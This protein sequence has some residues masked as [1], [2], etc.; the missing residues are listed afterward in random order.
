MAV[1]TEQV[2][3]QFL[4]V[5]TSD[6]LQNDYPAF[7]AADVY[8]FY[9]LAGNAA[10]RN[11][12]Y[13]VQLGNELNDYAFTVTVL[14]SLKAKID[15]MI[16]ADPDE[17]NK[18]VVR[19][20]MQYTTVTQPGAVS[21]TKFTSQEFDRTAMKLMQVAEASERS[22]KLGPQYVDEEPPTLR[23]G[24]EGDG[25]MFGPDNTIIP[26]PR[27]SDIGNVPA[28]AAQ[29]VVDAAQ[30][31]AD[32]VAVH[33]DKLAADA[34]AAS[35]LDSK[36][37]AL[38]T[39]GIPRG[40]WTTA[41]AYGF[42]DIARNGTSQYVC[43]VAHTSGVFATD[44]SAG[45]WAVW[46]S[47]GAP[48]AGSGDMSKSTYDPTA[49]NADAFNMAN[50]VESAA[51]SGH[52]KLSTAE[53]TKLSGIEAGAQVVSASRLAT[54][55]SG[56]SAGVPTGS[57][58]VVILSAGG[59]WTKALFSAVATYMASALG[60]TFAALSHSHSFA[61]IVSKPSTRAGYGITDAAPLSPNAGAVGSYAFCFTTT[62]G[63]NDFGD[64]RSG[65]QLRPCNSDDVPATGSTLSGTW[66]CMGN[67]KAGAGDQ[68]V[69]LWLRVS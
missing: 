38:Q 32:R 59:A 40:D 56:V 6:V 26:G 17:E 35:A 13:T 21:N 11:T 20:I 54:T 25:L 19:R 22:V 58:Y 4:N 44:V 51:G 1:T 23:L 46:V 8:V 61:D 53:R 57:D 55:T 49:K 67:T 68:V 60:T 16:A 64:T 29:V 37:V 52:L 24:V 41:T 65:S 30:V 9:G 36:N 10:V 12:D 45:K 34:D 63:N 5:D 66:R 7:D 3:E 33:A 50:M 14:A 31:A 48:G 28:L 18:V 69:T 15:A 62:G 47:D 43:L 2:A 42:A 27:L 39:K